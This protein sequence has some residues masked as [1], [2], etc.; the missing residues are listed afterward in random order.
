M[1]VT[2]AGHV[3]HGKTS[4]V[5]ALTGVDTD[6]LAEE[7]RRGLTIDIGFA[8]TTIDG[9][10]IGFVDVP[11]HHRFVHNM[12]AGVAAHQ[13][14]LVV[15]AVDDGVMPQTREHLAILQLLGVTRGVVAL[16][17]VDRADA[18]RIAEVR[19]SAIA[20]AETSGLMLSGTVET[21][22]M[23]GAGLDDLRGHIARAAQLHRADSCDHEFRLAIDRAFVIKG[24]GV[25]VTGTVHS[26]ALSRGDELA[27]APSGVSARARSLRVSDEP[28][29]RASVSDR[30]AVNLA[31]VSLEQVARGDW[32]VA[33]S[34][35][36]P[37]RHVVIAL[38][39]LDD[40]P[41][42]VRHW[43]PIH[44]YHAASHAQGHVALLETTR[45]GAGQ[46]A[47]VE[48]VLDTPLHPKY[49]DRLI[50]RDAARELTIG[51]GA[52]IDTVSPQRGRRAPARIARL[53][54]QRA[55]DPVVALRTLLTNDDV[56]LEAFKRSRNLTDAALT[57]LL[58][59]VDPVH[60][61]R[62]GRTVLVSR[63][64]WQS[65]LEAL[66]AQISAYHKSAPHSPGLKADQI[67]RTGIVPKRWLDDALAALV[68]QHRVSES[69]GHFH[70]PAHRPALPP[71]D[72]AL[73]KRI[74]AI[75]GE[76]DRP[77]SIGDIAKALATPL[78]P[79]DGFVARMSK[80]GLLVRVGDNRVLLSRHV[81]SLSAIAQEL[82]LTRPEGF[83]ARE[84]RDAARIGR[85]FSIDVLE[86]FDRCGYTRRYGD[87]RR[88]VGS[89]SMLRR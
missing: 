64:G 6:S 45:V 24:T 1:I 77:P 40:F 47:L 48:L 37:S 31:G 8:Y 41:R 55:E 52:V 83:S 82:L 15:V 59:A 87:L 14:A 74:E 57:S 63:D 89:P 75:I 13:Y 9:Q 16:T 61:Q 32:L 80:L 30:C 65:T 23:T 26:G 88:I 81:D 68:S 42:S 44:V 21:S 2:L 35:L 33:P 67:R 78:R 5:H 56:E 46:S 3:D 85:N 50:V 18:E 34:T 51:G 20:V 60:L 22:T 70:D 84:F 36:A 7:K 72:A 76:G 71:D 12:V 43:L 25:V 73:L 38:K 39:V 11:G 58:G 69:G 66:C 27:I 29:E 53:Q 28:A 17:K 54:A 10:R 79:L 4:L 49:G 19:R 62:D 86:Y